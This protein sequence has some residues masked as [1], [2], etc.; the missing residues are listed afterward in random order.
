MAVT[1]DDDANEAGA[2]GRDLL[3]NVCFYFH[4]AVMLYI[5]LGWLAPL[6]GALVFY[7]VF[8]PGVALQ[9]QFNKNAC[10]L[11]NLESWLRTGSWRDPNN[12]EEGQWLLTLV[13]DVTGLRFTPAQ[14]D[15]FTY[16]VLAM[17]WGLG[18]WHLLGW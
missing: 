17:L 8:V 14:M 6:R 3:G 15:A 4:F 18:L 9:W 5:V 10:V 16:G 7:L 1:P 11:N 12:R 13:R 2:A